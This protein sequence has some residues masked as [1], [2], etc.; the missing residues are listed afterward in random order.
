MSTFSNTDIEFLQHQ[1]IK[2]FELTIA[3]NYCL[4]IWFR[5]ALRLND[6]YVVN[7]L[8]GL[9]QPYT[10]NHDLLA[11]ML[12]MI[13]GGSDRTPIG[14]ISS[15]SVYNNRVKR[16]LS[17]LDRFTRHRG[18]NTQLQRGGGPWR[19]V[20]RGA[21]MN[22]F[23]NVAAPDLPGGCLPGHGLGACWAFVWFQLVDC[24]PHSRQYFP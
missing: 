12:I 11:F 3:N 9:A 10:S 5:A 2:L 23:N 16:F 4:S 8:Q 17:P 24:C 21:G 1:K 20:T 14:G 22:M 15:M 13:Q 18:W 7:R 19:C 6:E